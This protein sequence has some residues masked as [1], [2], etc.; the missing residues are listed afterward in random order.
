VRLKP[1]GPPSPVLSQDRRIYPLHFKVV[2]PSRPYLL[3]LRSQLIYLIWLPGENPV[4]HFIKFSLDHLIHV[5]PIVFAE[6]VN[7]LFPGV[8]FRGRARFKISLVKFLPKHS[9][10]SKVFLCCVDNLKVSSFPTLL[11]RIREP[12]L[13]F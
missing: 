4:L 6:E 11:Y 13:L 2:L 12:L 9:I 5:G 8:F 7:S 10:E 3:L 1:R